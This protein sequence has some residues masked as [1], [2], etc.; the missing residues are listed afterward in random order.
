[1]C[2]A[3]VLVYNVVGGGELHTAH[4]GFVTITSSG[5]QYIAIYVGLYFPFHNAPSTL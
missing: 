1:M 4:I 2:G 5:V 3:D